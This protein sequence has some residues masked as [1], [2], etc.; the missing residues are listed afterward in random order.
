MALYSLAED[1]DYIE[2]KE[3]I[4]RDRLVVGIRELDDMHVIPAILLLIMQR[5][6]RLHQVGCKMSSFSWHS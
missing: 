4:I 6:M 5:E 3:E 2:W 1:C